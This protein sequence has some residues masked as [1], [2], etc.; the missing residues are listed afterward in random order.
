MYYPFSEPSCPTSSNPNYKKISGSCIY[1][2]TSEKTHS[3][4]KENCKSKFGPGST[5]RLLEPRSSVMNQEVYDAARTL[6]QIDDDASVWLGI[7]NFR[8]NSIFEYDSDS[9]AVISGLWESSQPNDQNNHHC[10]AVQETSGTV[11]G[12][13]ECCYQNFFF[14]ECFLDSALAYSNKSIFS[15]LEY[16]SAHFSEKYQ[17][18]P[19]TCFRTVVGSFMF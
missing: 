7:T 15:Q 10:V 1:F 18:I 19:L 16:L 17:I 6:S 3:D 11:L 13:H 2:E 4:A 12:K 9:Q 8:D 5:G 14:K